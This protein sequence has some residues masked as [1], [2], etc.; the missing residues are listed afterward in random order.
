MATNKK[1]ELIIQTYELLK[2]TAPEDI[3]IRTI[4]QACNCTTPVIYKHFRDLDD[5]IH[6]SAVR[7]LE[8]YI[9]KTQ[10]ILTENDD[11]LDMLTIMWQE[12]AKCAFQNIDIFLML[13]WG[14]NRRQLGDTIYEY[15]HLFPSEWKDLGGLFTSTFFN[16]DIKERNY[17]IVRRAAS[18]GYFPYMQARQISDM[19]CFLIHGVL[20]DYKEVYR[21]PGK[22]DEGFSYFMELLQSHIQHY[23]IK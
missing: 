21:Q 2:H 18:A 13:F 22:A 23:R 14:Q 8:E 15:Y 1:T 20:L 3:K 17:M 11:P 6:F 19:Q 5:L 16:N 4:A 7:F 10:E 12:F 9:T